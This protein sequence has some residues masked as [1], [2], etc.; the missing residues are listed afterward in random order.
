[1]AEARVASVIATDAP[2]EIA[3][4]DAPL[5][6]ETAIGRCE[7]CGGT[8]TTGF[9]AGY[10]YELITCRNR[11]EFRECTACRHVWLDP[12]PSVEALGTIYPSTYYSYN[13]EQIPAV[14]RRAKELIDS[15]KMRKILA[16]CG[17]VPDRYLDVGCGDGRYLDALARRGVPK[18]GLFGLELD[19]RIVES[20]QQRGLQV[21]C[22]RVESCD[23]FEPGTFDLITMFHVIEHIDSPRTAVARLAEWLAPGGVLAVETPN[24]DSLDAHLFRDGKWGGYHIPRHWHLF[25]PSTL[26]R[27]LES[28]GLE[29]EAVRYE[30]GHAFWMYSFHHA[31]RYREPPR[32]RLARVFDPLASVAPLA[33]FTAFDRMR[34]MLGAKTS[35]MLITARLPA[36]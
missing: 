6:A 15:L 25:R 7:V 16:L 8:E 31:L 18:S 32:P 2:A 26:S 36:R 28:V 14:A 22:E 5:V 12:R 24:L 29:V 27:L 35:S 4:S 33:A 11:W 17:R 21:F 30:T 1:V 13:Y 3:A 20:L 10:D 23:R 34:A 19:E 9:A